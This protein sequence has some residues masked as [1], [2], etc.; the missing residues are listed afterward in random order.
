[1]RGRYRVIT[2]DIFTSPVRGR[3]GCLCECCVRRSVHGAKSMRPWSE[4][5]MQPNPVAVEHL[6][7][8][9]TYVL[10]PLVTMTEVGSSNIKDLGA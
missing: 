5:P 2:F 9:H 8:G 10:E 7:Y 4:V 1:M 6:G 3:L